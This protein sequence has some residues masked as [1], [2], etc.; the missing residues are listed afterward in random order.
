[1]YTRI[2]VCVYVYALCVY[3]PNYVYIVYMCVHL[4]VC[5]CASIYMDVV[6]C[7]CIRVCVCVG[8]CR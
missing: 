7:E 4:H 5:I 8:V 1:M 6:T 2:H 3:R